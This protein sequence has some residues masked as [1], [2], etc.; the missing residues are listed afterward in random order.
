M[1]ATSY[2]NF[3]KYA[4]QKRLY[5]SNLERLVFAL[6]HNLY[7]FNNRIIR[8]KKLGAVAERL[9]IALPRTPW[10]PIRFRKRRTRHRLLFHWGM[11]QIRRQHVAQPAPSAYGELAVAEKKRQGQ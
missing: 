1:A 10:I 8:S 5:A 2:L 4:E 6:M 3:C 11:K 9:G 7:C